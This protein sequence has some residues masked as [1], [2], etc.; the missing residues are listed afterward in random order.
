MGDL[1]P[2]PNI[3]P[4]LTSPTKLLFLTVGLIVALILLWLGRVIVLL[5]FASSVV[6][7]LLTAVVGWLD[8]KFKI[9]K[10]TSFALILSTTVCVLVMT[11]WLSGPSIIEQFA[12]LQTDLP[13]AARQLME[14]VRVYG[15]GRWLL[16]QWSGYSQLSSSVSAAM[17]RIGGIVLS[18]ATVLSGLVLIGFLGLYLGAEPEV[19]FSYIERAT[20]LSYRATLN[21]CAAASVRNLRWWVLSQMLSMSAVGVIVACGLWALGVPL[22]GTLGVIAALLT[23]IPNVGPILSVV[24]AV[25]LAVA[26]SPM[27]GLLTVILFLTVHFLEGNVITPL[28]ERRIVRMPP[29]LTMTAQLLLAVIAGPLGLALAAPFAAAALGIFEVLFPVESIDAPRRS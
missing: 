24:P 27:K 18:T 19:Y 20:P 2:S 5:L 3:A 13:Q 16:E 14:R 25:L 22:A 28:L 29:A 12:N 23:F 8:K 4:T 11:V 17:T 15:W 21:A 1:I 9:G 7:V 26:I 6:A 10:R